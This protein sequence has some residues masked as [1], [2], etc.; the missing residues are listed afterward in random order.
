MGMYKTTTTTEIRKTNKKGVGNVT[1]STL[2]IALKV[3]FMSL[4]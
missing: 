4:S 1:L 2:S 3:L